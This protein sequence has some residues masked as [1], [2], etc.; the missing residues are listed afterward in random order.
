[1]SPM[2]AM[3]WPWC[4]ID[5]ALGLINCR[6]DRVFD[7]LES[8]SNLITNIRIGILDAIH[9]CLA[10]SHQLTECGVP[11]ASLL[12]VHNAL[13]V[14]H[15]IK[16]ALGKLEYVLSLGVK[17]GIGIFRCHCLWRYQLAEFVTSL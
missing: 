1:M 3:T 4:A 6:K 9:N 10:G 5:P 17:H 11:E 12:D 15:E 16:I 2:S 7:V 13:A 14:L 8:L